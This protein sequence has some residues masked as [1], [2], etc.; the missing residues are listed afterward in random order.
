MLNK[1][2]MA[3]VMVPACLL[4]LSGCSGVKVETINRIPPEQIASEKTY[5]L[6]VQ[7]GDLQL[8][9]FLYEFSYHEVG[10]YLNLVEKEEAASGT[11]DIIFTTIG[12]NKTVSSSAGLAS[13]QGWYTGAGTAGAAA[14]GSSFSSS[15]VKTKQWSTMVVAIKG[16]DG[17]RLWWADLDFTG[18]GSV[19]TPSSAARYLSKRLASVMED[20]K[21]KPLPKF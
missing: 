6:R 2:V 17:E 4:I 20:S 14:L 21:F 12:H 16:K 7:T 11:I 9:Q 8:N 19:K 1:S 3:S 13:A 15:E 18:K 5:F 10:Q